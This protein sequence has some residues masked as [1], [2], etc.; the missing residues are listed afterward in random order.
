MRTTLFVTLIF[1][2]LFIFAWTVYQ[3]ELAFLNERNTLA[4]VFLNDSQIV[5]FVGIDENPSPVSQS[6]PSWPVGNSTITTDSV[7]NLGAL[8]GTPGSDEETEESILV[9]NQST[10]LQGI[11]PVVET[12]TVTT[13]PSPSSG[14]SQSTPAI[15]AEET[16]TV[17]Q[18]ITALLGSQ[19]V[20]ALIESVPEG[21]GAFGLA[22]SGIRL[23]FFGGRIRDVFK[24]LG[25][26][27]ISIPN[28][29]TLLKG[30]GPYSV[31]FSQQE[32]TL[33][34]ASAVLQDEYID[35][36]VYANGVLTTSYRALGR[37]F[38]V[39]PLRYTLK[40]TT[41]FAQGT[42]EA[43]EVRFPWYSFFLAKGMSGSALEARIKAQ[44]VENVRG[45]SSEYDVTTRAF[46]GIAD[47][48]RVRLG[49]V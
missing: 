35:S 17:E 19:A 27:S 30:T 45:F 14:G 47:V 25:V 5:E 20:T 12:V 21:G 1:S 3:K 16:I 7:V 29:E 11:T 32:F 24:A 15:T 6:S 48:L 31:Q 28:R 34:V 22:D 9:F 46:V 23:Q 38:G 26:V 8:P 43:V 13:A 49:G 2:S 33:F 42:L 18:I 10:E 4:A 44:I 37:L 39:V 40:V 41:T 36:V